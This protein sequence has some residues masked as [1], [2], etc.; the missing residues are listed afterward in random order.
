[1]LFLVGDNGDGC[2]RVEEGLLKVTMISRDGNERI[3]A[4]LGPGAIVGEMSI[5]D[6]LHAAR[7]S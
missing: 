3:L 1:V 4:F 6:Q 7:P 2:Y 5:I